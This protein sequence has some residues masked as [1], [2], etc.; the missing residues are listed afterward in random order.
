ME[1][2]YTKFAVRRAWFFAR[3]RSLKWTVAVIET[4]RPSRQEIRSDG[5]KRRRTPG[6]SASGGT[7]PMVLVMVV[8]AMTVQF[9][10]NERLTEMRARLVS[11]CFIHR[12][13][14]GR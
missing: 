9:L 1:S 5:R 11:S 3:L 6:R 14:D 4:A 8:A 2:Q 12:E 7:A 13:D 10:E